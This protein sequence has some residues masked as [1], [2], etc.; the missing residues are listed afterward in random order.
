[1]PVGTAARAPRRQFD[2]PRSVAAAGPGPPTPAWL[3]GGQRQVR[4]MR[5]ALDSGPS[6]GPF[7]RRPRCGPPAVSPRPRPWS[8]GVGQLS[9][10]A[11]A[12]RWT[13]VL[14]A[15]HDAGLTGSHHWRRSSRSPCARSL[16]LALATTFSVSAAKPTT[17]RGRARPAA[18]ARQDVGIF[19]QRDRRR[20]RARGFLDLLLAAIVGPP[21]GHRRRE[22]RDVGRQRRL[23]GRQHLARRLDAM[24][25]DA[26]GRREIDRP[27]DQHRLG[28]RARQRRRRWHSPACREE[29]LAM[30]RTGSIGSLR[31]SGGDQHP[32]AG[33]AVRAGG[34]KCCFDGR[35]DLQPARPSGPGRTRRRPSRRSLGPTSSTPSASR[36]R[37]LRWVAGVLSHIRTFIAGAISTG[38][39]VASSAVEAR[40]LARPFAIL[41]IRSAV[42]GA[43]T[44]RSAARD[45]SIWPISASSVRLKRSS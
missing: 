29:R 27:G 33:Q 41:A 18:R 35:K 6:C 44:T 32:P 26:G 28:A 15:A 37:R 21:V 36:L 10:P 20:H 4:P 5:Q 42:A 40:S 14:V 38:L 31:G 7:E 12:D 19:H 3:I 1:M 8:F 9:M 2:R 39:S 11:S 17:S 23:A 24:Q 43:T 22:D 16:A 34:A 25:P 13:R 45:S 30:K